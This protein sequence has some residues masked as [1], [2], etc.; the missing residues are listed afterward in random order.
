MREYGHQS[1][2]SGVVFGVSGMPRKLD[3]IPTFYIRRGLMYVDNEMTR[4]F[5][6]GTVVSVIY[7]FNEDNPQANLD[8]RITQERIADAVI[9]K[10]NESFI[11]EAKP[12]F[13]FTKNEKIPTSQLDSSSPISLEEPFGLTNQRE[14]GEFSE[15]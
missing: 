9:A 13:G 3:A 10:L 8:S 15:S 5:L 6:R 2:T 4:Q 14:N 12:E 7:Y 1:R 11:I